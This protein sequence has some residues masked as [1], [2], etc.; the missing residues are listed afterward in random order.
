L[1]AATP[2]ILAEHA[3]GEAAAAAGARGCGRA[4][5]AAVGALYKLNP[6]N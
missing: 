4:L 3:L 1:C 6:V 5:D 2:G